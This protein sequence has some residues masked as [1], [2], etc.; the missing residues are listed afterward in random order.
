MISE[1]Q[2]EAWAPKGILNM[3]I[4]EQLKNLSVEDM[5]STI[6][7]ARETGIEEIY[8]WGAEWWWYLKLK[9]YPQLWETAREEFGK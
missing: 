7:Y 8:A 2:L 6:K 5:R 1:L 4:E 9:G 3:T